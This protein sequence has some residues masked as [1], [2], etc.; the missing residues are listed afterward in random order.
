MLIHEVCQKCSL[1]KKAI[2]Y[3]ISQELVSPAVQHN[4]YR[5]FSEEDVV[6]L[7]KISVLRS[8]GL[9]VAEIHTALS[10]PL[11]TALNEISEKKHIEITPLQEKQKL[12]RELAKSHDWEQVH[13]HLQQLEKK[14]SVLERLNNVFP[15]CYGR[16]VSLHFAPY[17]NEPIVT[18]EQQEAFDTIIAFLDTVRFN[19]S[20]ELQTYLDEIAAHFDEAF[21]ANIAAYA[22]DAIRDTGKYIAEHREVIEN[23]I[24][25]KQSEE[26]KATPAYGLEKSLREF[27][28]ASGY[29]E[30]FIPAMCRLSS[31]YRA[32]FDGLQKADEKFLEEFPQY[33]INVI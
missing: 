23:Y 30:I 13:N 22:N 31:S 15:G 20:D 25:F 14:Q 21:A 6:L 5:S 9:S 24:A 28:E 8:L 12:I 29:N 3:Y 19:L 2:E 11:E 27:T 7:K 33:G 16:F 32:Y 10:K 18:S 26:Y 1:T 17:L 4:G